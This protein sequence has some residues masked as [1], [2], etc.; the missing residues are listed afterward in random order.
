MKRSSKIVLTALVLTILMLGL[1]LVATKAVLNSTSVKSKIENAV[2]DTLGMPFKIEGRINLGFLPVLWLA[3]NNIRV[4][5]ATDTIASADQIKITPRLLDLWSLKVHIKD[6]HIQNPKL[7]LDQQAIEKLQGLKGDKS[8]GYQP[9]ESLVIDS[10]SISN[11]EFFYSD[12][13]TIV[14]LKEM[15]IGGGGL[16]IIENRKFT[17]DDVVSFFRAINFKGDIA[18]GQIASQ[19]FKLENIKVSVKGENGLL[20][21]DPIEL[22]YFGEQAKI[23][24]FLNLKENIYNVQIR[25]EMPALNL[26]NFRRKAGEKDIIKGVIHLQGE[27][28]ASG[29]F[30]D[31]ML[32]NV[33]GNFSIK[34]RN[35][36][37]KGIDFDKALDEF[38]EIRGYGFNDFAILV[39]LGPLGVVVSHGYDHLDALEKIMAA[40]GDSA[41]QVLVSDWS[42]VKGVVTARDVA[43]ST[44]RNR[45]AVKGSLDIPNGKFN[46]V[47]IA[48]VDA[49][50]CIVNS[51][52]VEGPF[53]NPEVKEAGV[54]ERTVIRP[55]KRMFK[56]ECEF[57]YGG[58]VPQPAGQ[59]SE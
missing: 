16:S 13:Q 19:D 26:E 58:A 51:E 56:A 24:G 1:A 3:G 20:A 54:L 50:G 41:I 14:D 23:A 43:F 48:I 15:D 10:F 34:G 47:I 36:A 6:L 8:D 32:R 2:S 46:N 57:F 53:E 30:I 44:Q 21:A 22:Q 33:T 38:K 29:A 18:T 35:L 37:L 49:E 42:V 5:T 52:T 27:A 59:G 4:G 7:K 39:M 17:I 25:A 55:L 11:L 12:D 31:E 28:E 45:V 9:F 40:T